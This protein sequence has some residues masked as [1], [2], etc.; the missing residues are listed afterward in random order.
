MGQRETRRRS[1]LES[2]MARW[3]GWDTGGPAAQ[4]E[5]EVQ[6]NDFLG[7]VARSKGTVLGSLELDVLSWLTARWYEQQRD[8]DGLIRC[9]IYELGVDLY[10]RKPSGKEVRLLRGAVENLAAALITLG[11]YNAHSGQMK[12]KFQSMVHLVE[13][14]V[15]AGDL[16]FAVPTREHGAE[17]GGLRGNSFEIKLASWLVRQLEQKYVTYL[18]WRKQRKLDGLAKRLWVYLEAEQYKPSG[19][20]R[21][22][23]YIILGE[24]A[25]TA[26]GVHHAR[27]RDRRAALKRAAARIV[28]VDDHYEDIAVEPNP[29]NR[30]TWRILATRFADAERREVASLARRSLEQAAAS[31]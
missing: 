10:G 11:G 8:P 29:V 30:S 1:V 12:P 4:A 2:N 31:A 21:A 9:T 14:A 7:V 28:E 5:L 16:A 25:Y 17:T 6:G 23:S 18:D 24:K 20:G 13:S 3:G 19:H 26:L 22:R 15:W 27:D